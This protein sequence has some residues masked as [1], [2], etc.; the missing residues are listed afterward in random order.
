MN[1]AVTFEVLSSS[2]LGSTAVRRDRD[3]AE[4]ASR[5]ELMSVS[6]SLAP[7]EVLSAPVRTMNPPAMTRPMTMQA[8]TSSVR[9]TPASARYARRA[10]R[11]RRIAH[12]RVLTFAVVAVVRLLG[13]IVTVW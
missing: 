9:V 8:T 6:R 10:R 3:I 13:M 11:A 1:A 12:G 4:T 5:A 7:W 2:W